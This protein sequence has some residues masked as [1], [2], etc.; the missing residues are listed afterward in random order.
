MRS[1][2]RFCFDRVSSLVD[3]S[4]PP[5]R[6]HDFV[7]Q[8]LGFALKRLKKHGVSAFPPSTLAD[9]CR[10]S[11][12][13]QEIGLIQSLP[14]MPD[15][16]PPYDP[17]QEIGPWLNSLTDGQVL[18]KNVL[19]AGTG[20]YLDLLAAQ[21]GRG[22]GELVEANLEI[23]LRHTEVKRRRCFSALRPPAPPE[24][25]W[26]ERHDIAILFCHQARRYGD[27]RFLNAAF[28]LNDWAFRRYRGCSDW[29]RLCRY[30]KALAEQEKA[31]R[32][33]LR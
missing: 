1:F 17:I 5:Q 12:L 2:L 8:K 25:L 10:A 22:H 14:E 26:F 6:I 16:T 15:F 33:L 31:A 11:A 7:R 28:K 20:Q 9:L 4:V 19:I 13:A 24:Q 23:L 30:L 29:K 21:P 27:L 18:Q 32:E 3:D